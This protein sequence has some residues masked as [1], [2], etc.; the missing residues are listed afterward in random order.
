LKKA[1]DKVLAAT[2]ARSDVALTAGDTKRMRAALDERMATHGLPIETSVDVLRVADDLT[3]TAVNIVAELRPVA[4]GGEPAL[5]ASAATAL[6]DAA[7]IE[8]LKLRSDPPRL[9]VLVTSAEI[10]E[11][12]TAENVTRLHLKVAEEGMEWTSI[13]TNGV[14]RD[15]LVPE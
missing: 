13:E 10:R 1:F 11:G 4:H 15:R 3:A 7:R 9:T 14:A 8:F 12:G 5:S 2:L 6:R